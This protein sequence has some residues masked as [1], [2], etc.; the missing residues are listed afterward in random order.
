M[1][2]LHRTQS[3]SVTTPAS[4]RTHL[5][6]TFALIILT[7]SAVLARLTGNTFAAT[8][9]INSFDEFDA[10]MCE[11]LVIEIQS[12]ERPSQLQNFPLNNVP[13]CLSRSTTLCHL[14]ITPNDASR[15]LT[16]YGLSEPYPPC[17]LIDNSGTIHGRWYDDS[18]NESLLD[19][20]K[21]AVFIMQSREEMS[22]KS[23]SVRDWRDI[24]NWSS[25]IEAKCMQD[26]DPTVYVMVGVDT[27]PLKLGNTEFSEDLDFSNFAKGGFTGAAMDS[28]FRYRFAD[29]YGDPLKLTWFVMTSE[30]ICNSKNSECDAVYDALSN[31]Y[32][33]EIEIYGD[34]IQLHYHNVEW[35][36]RD[37]NHVFYWNQRQYFE[38]DDMEKM[39]NYL[40]VEKQFF[41]SAFRAGWTWENSEMSLFLEEVVPFDYS[42]NAPLVKHDFFHD[43]VA[44]VFDWSRAPTGWG[45]YHPS[46]DDYQVPGA[47]RRLV[48]PCLSYTMFNRSIDGAFRLA[49]DGECGV[50][51]SDYLH[52]TAPM[53]PHIRS[54]YAA[55][56][57]KSNEYGVRF[58][59]VSAAEGAR[60]A[61]GSQ[62]TVKPQLETV[63]DTI[64]GYRTIGISSSERL[65]AKPYVVVKT[66][67]GE[68]VRILVKKTDTSSWSASIPR[69]IAENAATVTVGACDLSG[70]TAVSTWQNR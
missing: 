24:S 28:S 35:S 37:G 55:L 36:D 19:S 12:D 34:E 70:N 50:L 61:I 6:T 1:K 29:S 54:V 64:D 13:D 31:G 49:A 15:L 65:F 59:W 68:R 16:R 63:C 45:Y 10:E 18:Y 60:L 52:N 51:V 4:C 67:T 9:V 20:V 8:R 32:R 38:R 46:R 21:Q 27:E 5:L 47:M 25:D 69:V 3:L 53:L 40:L 11:L 62:D 23:R 2:R 41:G 39:I 22:A 58:I 56:T 7:V 26:S 48:F 30:Q 42:S 57:E 33:R 17:V 44:G 43:P 14:K 66:R